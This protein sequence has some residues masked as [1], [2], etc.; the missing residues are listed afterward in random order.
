MAVYLSTL[1][2]AYGPL[3]ES[4]W[5]RKDNPQHYTDLP[6]QF[7]NPAPH[8]HILGFVGGNEVSVIK[9]SMV[10]LESDLRGINLP[11]TF[12]PAQQYQPPMRTDR[13][14]IRENRKGAVRIEVDP[15][16]LP[17][18]QMMAYPAV[19]APQPLVNEV[20]QRPEKY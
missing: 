16:H 18:Y 2:E 12:C 11:N 1:G 5:E 3:I 14:I 17:T 9:G 20:C 19:I 8:R 4:H 7:V 6:S 10:D 15:V 13:E